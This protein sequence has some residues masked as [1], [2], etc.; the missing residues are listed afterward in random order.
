MIFVS[1]NADRRITFAVD[2]AHFARRQT[3]DDIVAF[4]AGDHRT[5]TG[6]TRE[7][8][9]APQLQFDIVHRKTDGNETERQRVADRRSRRF[10][11][12]D[13]LSDL[14]T[15]RRDDIALVAVGI[16]HEGDICAAVRIVFDRFYRTGNTVFIAFKIDVS[17]LPFVSAALMAHGNPSAASAARV[18][19]HT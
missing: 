13:L 19:H 2:S 11:R 7:L 1:D 4:V 18:R 10:A 14:Q 5:R 16:I 17:I 6:R 9:A 12:H 8:S 3:D 15:L